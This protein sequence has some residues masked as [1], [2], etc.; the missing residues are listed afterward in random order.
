MINTS[1]ILKHLLFV[2]SNYCFLSGLYL[3]QQLINT[4]AHVVHYLRTNIY[5]QIEI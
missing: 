5:L 1:D 3:L 4:V 2:F